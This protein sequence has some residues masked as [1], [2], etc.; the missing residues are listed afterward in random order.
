[1]AN[2][3]LKKNEMPHQAPE[4]RARNFQEVALGYTPEQA[5][6]EAN[7]CLGCKNR[8]CVAGCPVNID[9]PEFLNFMF[10]LYHNKNVFYILFM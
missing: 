8:S 6:D 2:M 9:I 5:I 1:M 3:S 4:V 10:G 7:R